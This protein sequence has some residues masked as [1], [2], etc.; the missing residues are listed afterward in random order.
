M[1]IIINYLK[2]YLEGHFHLKLYLSVAVFLSV[3]TYFNYK[4]D[5]E[6]SILD[7]YTGSELKWLFMFMHMSFPFLVT[8]VFLYLYKIETSWVKSKEFWIKFFVGFAIISFD[9]QFYYFYDIIKSLPKA[10]YYFAFKNISWGDSLLANVVP[11]LIFYYF[12]EKNSDSEKHWY[13][14]TLKKFDIKPYALLVVLVFG[15]M[16][17][18]SFMAELNTYYPRYKHSGGVDFAA[19]HQIPEF[20]SVL[21]YELV[22]GSYYISVE[23]F[24]RGFLVIAFARTLGGHA[25]LAMVGSYVFLH[26]GKPLPETISSAFGGYL[27]GILAFYTNRIWGGVI[28][29]V[30]LAWSMELF[31]WLQNLSDR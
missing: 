17:I 28:L 18:A 15:G 19:F 11:I 27:I 10:D 26:F 23:L 8:C 7:S 21:I 5:F 22:Y 9:R 3:C 12:Y 31:A 29:H 14:L 6:D 20:I 16:A 25:V 24:F 4:Y 13:G 2:K 1:R 30:A